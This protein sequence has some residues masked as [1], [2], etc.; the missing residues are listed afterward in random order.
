MAEVLLGA[1]N[2][3]ELQGWAGL[4]SALPRLAEGEPGAGLPPLWP[5]QPDRE[6]AGV[7]TAQAAEGIHEQLG[8][9]APDAGP[10][11]LCS[12]GRSHHRADFQ[13]AASVALQHLRLQHLPQPYWQPRRMQQPQASAEWNTLG[14]LMGRE[15]DF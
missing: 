11:S 14:C 15:E 9:A 6:G 3:G 10:N 1:G 5:G 7:H 13:G 12:A 8:G 4:V 2:A